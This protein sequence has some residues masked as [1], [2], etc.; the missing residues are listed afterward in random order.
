M[1]DVK[2][3]WRQIGLATGISVTMTF[4]T[5]LI[6][7]MM[8]DNRNPFGSALALTG[9]MSILFLFHSIAL[10]PMA[11]MGR[12]QLKAYWIS[13]GVVLLTVLGLVVAATS[14]WGHYSY[15]FWLFVVPIVWV[16]FVIYATYQTLQDQLDNEEERVQEF[17]RSQ[18]LG[19]SL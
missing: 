5:A 16:V 13:L 11:R 18:G 3:S 12:K 1:L 6:S 9:F 2:Y 15:L 7:S 17:L 4:A 10:M 8:A 19:E 14:T